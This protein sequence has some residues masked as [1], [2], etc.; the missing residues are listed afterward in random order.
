MSELGAQPV[1]REEI[2]RCDEEHADGQIAPTFATNDDPDGRQE[3]VAG[4]QKG[5]HR[6]PSPRLPDPERCTQDDSQVVGHHLDEVAL[7]DFDEPADP[8]PPTTSSVAQVGEASLDHLGSPS[9]QRAAIDED[10]LRTALADFEPVWDELFTAERVRI[11]RL[12]VED[13]R[14]DADRSEVSIT[15]RPGGVRALAAEARVRR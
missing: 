8:R 7:A 3:A 4:C 1:P 13:V 5:V 15:F 10:D 2:T 6:R 14:F 12:L 11:V 9:L